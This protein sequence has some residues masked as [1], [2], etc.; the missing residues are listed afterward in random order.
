[1]GSRKVLLGQIAAGVD[2]AA[3]RQAARRAERQGLA[4]PTLG[5]LL[6]RYLT[7]HADPRKRAS[8]ASSDESL[9]SR[10]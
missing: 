7:E 2:P 6:D 9:I 4:A 10:G 1:V 8:S 3:D 5:Q